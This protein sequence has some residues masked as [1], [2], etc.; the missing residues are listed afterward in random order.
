VRDPFRN[1]IGYPDGVELCVSCDDKKNSMSTPCV[2]PN[3]RRSVE[4]QDKL[5]K[6]KRRQQ[7]LSSLL[8]PRNNNIGRQLLFELPHCAC[9]KKH[10]EC[11]GDWMEVEIFNSVTRSM[12]NHNSRLFDMCAWCASMYAK[13]T[14]VTTHY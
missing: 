6:E 11:E 3:Q 9:C 4:F 7:Q 14:N 8:L 5:R 1:L 12:V 2:S 13:Y 10:I